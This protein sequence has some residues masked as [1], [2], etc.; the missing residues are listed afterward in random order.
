MGGD[1]F[2]YGDSGNDHIVGD[3]GWDR[4][5]GGSGNDFLEGGDGEDVI[6]GG[7]GDDLLSGGT[8]E[9]HF[10]YFENA[11]NDVILDFKP[12]EDFVDLRLL[13]EAIGFSDPHHR[14]R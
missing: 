5:I 4:L 13:P 14:G 6:L 7:A 10:V 2:L 3:A 12:G 1:D 9:D 11:G 8:R